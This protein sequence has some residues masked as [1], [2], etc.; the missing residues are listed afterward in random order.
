MLDAMAHEVRFSDYGA[1]AAHDAERDEPPA[2]DE[3]R[4]GLAATAALDPARGTRTTA[5][6]TVLLLQ[7]IWTDRA[8]PPQACAAMR[9]A[10]GQQLTRHRIASGF[11]SSV[12]AAATSG[13]LMGIARNEAGVVTFP[14]GAAYAVAVFT[15]TRPRTT[16]DP[17]A[18]DAGIGR[19]ARSVDRPVAWDVTGA[20]SRDQ[21]D[22]RRASLTVRLPGRE[23]TSAC[24]RRSVA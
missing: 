13:G 17:A 10:M 3:I 22:P 12:A 21:E 15:R 1:L 2:A 9:T 19:I 24:D 18:V 16:C 14:D 5:A 20:R 11:G 8:G 6:E 7:A 4:R 23:T